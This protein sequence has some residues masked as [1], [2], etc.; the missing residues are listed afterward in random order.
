MGI[1]VPMNDGHAPTLVHPGFVRL[2]KD[3]GGHKQP[4]IRRM[5][6]K[7]V[8]YRRSSEDCNRRNIFV[9]M[10]LS[11]DFL[12]QKSRFIF[13]MELT[14]FINTPVKRHLP[15]VQFMRP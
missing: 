6:R 7:P 5:R 13:Q 8:A 4:D 12:A 2:E 11:S 10:T 14:F 15:F 9:F 3:K 1:L